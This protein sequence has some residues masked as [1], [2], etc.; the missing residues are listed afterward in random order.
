MIP[1]SAQK[2]LARAAARESGLDQAARTVLFGAS[3]A[4]D[5]DP[6]AGYVL[7]HDAWWVPGSEHSPLV[8]EIVTVHHPEYYAT[9]GERDATDFD[10]PVPN[11]QV[12]AHGCFLFGVECQDLAWSALA[13]DLLAGALQDLGIGGKTSAGYGRFV[14]DDK[15]TDRI[16]AM[17]KHEELAQ[18]SP[19]DRL[20]REVSTLTE[21]QL[22]ERLSKD[23]NKWQ[24]KLAADWETFLG[25]I[26]EMHGERVRSWKDSPEKHR[27]KAYKTL[28][29][30]SGGD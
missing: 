4:G 3:E 7:F 25:L 17:R 16:A 20:R 26:R 14:V 1:G 9:E 13:R 24:R 29:A 5:G 21:T 18:L 27:S 15:A 10:S 8:P 11:V 12:A 23:R 22:A 28:F 6:D 30:R 2:G 19:A